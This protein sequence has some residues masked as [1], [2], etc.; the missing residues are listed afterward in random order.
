MSRDSYLFLL[1]SLDQIDRSLRHTED[2]DQMMKD[3]LDKTLSLFKS[4]RAWLVYPCDPK[5]DSW[6]APME[7]SRQGHPGVLI[8]T[9]D[10]PMLPETISVFAAALKSEGSVAY[11][12]S[13]QRALPAEAAKQFNI[14]SQITKAIYPRT[15]KPWL[16]VMHQC[17]HARVWTDDEKNLFREIGRR[18][19]DVLNTLL[20]LKDVRRNERKYKTVVNNSPDLIYRTDMNGVVTFVSESILNLSGYTV[21]EALGMR[22]AEEIYVN[23]DDRKYFLNKIMNTGSIE[24]FEAKLKHKNGTT[25]WASTNAHII[26]GSQGDIQGVEGVTR[27]ITEK[28]IAEVA[29]NQSEAYLRT[30]IY[31]IPDLVWLKDENGIY[32]FCNSKFERFFGAP[33]KDIIG[34]TDY[35][36]IDKKLAD[37][38]RKYDKEAMKKRKPSINEEEVTYADDGHHEILETIK[39]PMYGR[40]GNLIGVLGIAR[41]ITNRKQAEEK[42]KHLEEELRQSHKM[43]AIGTISGGIAHDFNNILGIILGNTELVLDST[44]EWN[45]N[46]L[47]LEEIKKASLRA[48]D[49]VRQLLHRR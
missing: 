40:D 12:T 34:K 23:P 46:R 17:S 3:V 37:L 24:N 31:T 25:W 42:R 36:F 5:A 33:E 45:P 38:F 43:E 15:G 4:D 10:I 39:T 2:L 20:L 27:N 11:D 16:F 49:V 22:M 29:L 9:R 13:T 41:D 32:L 47:N 21:E 1:E 19:A 8:G 48:S 18:I 44:E 35:D 26:K 28:K 14:Q 30:L 6:G 7:R